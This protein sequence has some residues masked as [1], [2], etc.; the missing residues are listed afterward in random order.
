VEALSTKREKKEL[1]RNMQVLFVRDEHRLDG[2]DVRA[3]FF[4]LRYLRKT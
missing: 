2:R 4:V 3:L 1:M